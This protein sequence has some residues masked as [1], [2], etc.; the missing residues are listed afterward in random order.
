MNLIELLWANTLTM[1]YT[2]TQLE[3]WWKTASVFDWPVW[4]TPASG[5]SAIFPQPPSGPPRG[6]RAGRGRGGSPAPLRWARARWP[7][8]PCT[9]PG[10]PQESRA[11][12]MPRSPL[13]AVCG[14]KWKKVAAVKK[15]S[16]TG[17]YLGKLILLLR[18]EWSVG[19]Q[20][21]AVYFVML[22]QIPGH[23]QNTRQKC[24][25]CMR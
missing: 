3:S 8:A 14:C 7:A 13:W 19:M 23:D 21:I 9:C 18:W 4:L 1:S 2:L 6:G 24:Y 10:S 15:I 5:R 11:G 22:T 17:I 25:A 20:R 12:P 16:L